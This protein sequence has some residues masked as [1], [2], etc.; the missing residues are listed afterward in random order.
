MGSSFPDPPSDVDKGTERYTVEEFV[1]TD[2]TVIAYVGIYTIPK[3]MTVNRDVE[4]SSVWECRP[5]DKVGRERVSAYAPLPLRA[6][7]IIKRAPSAYVRAGQSSRCVV[8]APLLSE[9]PHVR[10]K[11]C[12]VR[13]AP[14][15]RLRQILHYTQC[16]T[17]DK[18]G[19]QT[20]VCNKRRR[21]RN[22]AALQLSLA[23]AQKLGLD[24]QP[25]PDHASH[26]GPRTSAS[27]SFITERATVYHT[28]KPTMDAMSATVRYDKPS[29]IVLSA[30][31]VFVGYAEIR[32]MVEPKA[33]YISHPKTDFEKAAKKASQ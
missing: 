1:Q 11:L 15:N 30:P 4:S 2:D 29:M 12:T 20:T 22:R 10:L 3:M 5:S 25:P 32:A 18:L 19:L 16:P 21:Q 31:T 28:R 7:V 13:K 9:V 33:L 6:D 8:F 14:N 17:H 23:S 24:V 26:R 27:G